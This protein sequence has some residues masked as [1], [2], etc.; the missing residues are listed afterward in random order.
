LITLSGAGTD[1]PLKDLEEQKAL[2]AEGRILFA[3]LGCIA[4]HGLPSREALPSEDSRITLRSVPKKF[5]RGQISAFLRDPSAHYKAIRMPDFQLTQREADALEELLRGQGD[6]VPFGE[7][8]RGD[9]E[10]G[11]QWAET[12]DCKACHSGFGEK[13]G[14]VIP[15]ND[16]GRGCL[17]AEPKERIPAFGLSKAETEDLRSFLADP[18]ES[19]RRWSVFEEGDRL[20]R[21]LNCIACHDIEGH[22]DHWSQFVLETERYQAKREGDL[23]QARPNLSYAGEKLHTQWIEAFLQNPRQQRLR[24]WL[25]ARMPS[26][27]THGHDLAMGLASRHGVQA[28]G[29]VKPESSEETLDIGEFLIGA[30]GFGCTACHAL[31]GKPAYAQFEVGALEFNESFERLRLPFYER[32]MWN[33]RR[34]DPSSRMPVYVDDEGITQFDEILEGNGHRQFEAMWQYLSERAPRRGNGK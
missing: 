17:S 24:P 9:P 2:S 20:L 27:R 16:S 30:D 19:F 21:E 13:P 5:L 12:L 25:H 28:G 26:F 11:L 29:P 15:L 10:R 33:S 4:C 1:A 31:N 18:A 23:D 7:V 22:E 34:I 3:D 14:T 32:W 8:N 6:P